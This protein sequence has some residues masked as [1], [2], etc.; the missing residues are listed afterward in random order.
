MLHCQTFQKNQ[1][2]TEFANTVKEPHYRQ[3]VAF[4]DRPLWDRFVTACT[5]IDINQCIGNGRKETMNKL[6]P[7]GTH[8]AYQRHRRNGEPAC[9]ECLA[10]NAEYTRQIRTDPAIVRDQMQRSNARIK[11]LRRLAQ[12]YPER[13]QQLATE[14]LTKL[15]FPEV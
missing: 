9:V 6:F 11:A 15:T 1:R 7:C 3:D 5:A 10:A 13:Y 2:T 12:E 14:E 4:A 8:A